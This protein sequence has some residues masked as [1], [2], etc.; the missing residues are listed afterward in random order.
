MDGQSIIRA[1]PR[2]EQ[3]KACLL[4]EGFLP[5]THRE[6]LCCHGSGDQLLHRVYIVCMPNLRAIQCQRFFHDP[7]CLMSFSTVVTP[8]ATHLSQICVGVLPRGE[9]ISLSTIC[10]GV[11]QKEQHNSPARSWRGDEILCLTD[12]APGLVSFFRMPRHTFKQS[13]QIDTI[14][15]CGPTSRIMP[16]GFWQ[17]EHFKTFC[18]RK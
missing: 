18:M 17:K 13:W 2:A 3:T 7:T 14:R 8:A 16:W 1:F 10:C 6:V 11:S 4:D 5:S 9:P 15:V 12:S